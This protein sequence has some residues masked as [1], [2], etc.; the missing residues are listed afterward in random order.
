VQFACLSTLYADSDVAGIVLVYDPRSGAWSVDT[1]AAAQPG[2]LLADWTGQRMI[3]QAKI[4]TDTHCLRHESDGFADSDQATTLRV[5]TG[6]IRPWGTFGHGVINRIGLVHELR[7]ACTLSTTLTTE[8]GS[9]TST[10][11]YSGSAPDTAGTTQYLETSL[12]KDTLRDVNMLRVEI[13]ESSTSEGVALIHL[14][15]EHDAKPQGFKL[16]PIGKRVT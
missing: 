6:D 8:N 9:R 12:N 7:S 5:R 1:F 10:E 15:A 14:V 11:V 4:V 16:Q 13:S 3:A 2:L